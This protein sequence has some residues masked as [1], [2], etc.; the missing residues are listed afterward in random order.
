MGLLGVFI[1]AARRDTTGLEARPR[2]SSLLFRK[3]EAVTVGHNPPISAD[4]ACEF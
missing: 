4:N 2:H 1:V 3:R